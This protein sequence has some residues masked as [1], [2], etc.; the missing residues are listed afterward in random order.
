MSIEKKIA[1]K[2]Y[3]ERAITHGGGHTERRQRG[4][5]LE[6]RAAK[7]KAARIAFGDQSDALPYTEQRAALV[8]LEYD[9][10]TRRQRPAPYRSTDTRII[11]RAEQDLV[12][13]AYRARCAEEDAR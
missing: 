13:S 3:L 8:A 7:A 9:E 1:N 2:G 4:A 6:N 10:V 11:P 5:R 12:A